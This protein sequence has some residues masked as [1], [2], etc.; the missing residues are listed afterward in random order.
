M[1]KFLENH[2]EN[3]E[4]ELKRAFEAMLDMPDPELYTLVTGRAESRDKHINKVVECIRT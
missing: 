3:A 4:S 1:L 2:Y